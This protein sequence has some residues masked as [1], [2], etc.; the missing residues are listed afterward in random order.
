MGAFIPWTGN[1]S[2]LQAH[3]GPELTG[4]DNCSIGF[5]IRWKEPPS[6]IPC[7]CLN[8]APKSS[9]DVPKNSPSRIRDFIF[10]AKKKKK[11][12]YNY[13]ANGF[14]FFKKF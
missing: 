13:W 5:R 3:W 4:I 11:V 7:E 6:L 9:Q 8:S 14:R 1:R 10:V 12:S 2:P